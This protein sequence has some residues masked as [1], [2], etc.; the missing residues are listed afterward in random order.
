MNNNINEIT[1][2]DFR[3]K[4]KSLGF[5]EKGQELTSGGEINSAFLDILNKFFTEWKT[6]GGDNCPVTFTSG[7]DKFHK[8][9][10]TYT[11]RHT[12]GEAVDVV[13]NSG[14]H[15]K[16]IELLNKYKSTYYGFSFINEYTNP[17]SKATGPHFH[18]SYRSGAPEGSGKSGGE[19][20]SVST[21][22]A[23]IATSNTTGTD[24]VDYE[25]EPG[26]VSNLLKIAGFNENDGSNQS[27][28][29]ISEEIKRIK[30]LMK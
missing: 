16:F 2:S 9:I 21:D 23:S 4:I 12:K 18:L 3:T 14:C 15:S 10:K 1:S 8:G 13:L 29:T 24:I 6:I 26:I 19:S 30:T 7:N 27:I 17:T 20:S 25:Y 22:P 5:S 11:S 28:D